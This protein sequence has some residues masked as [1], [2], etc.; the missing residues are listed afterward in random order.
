M[1]FCEKK[2]GIM[3]ATVWEKEDPTGWYVFDGCHG[4][5]NRWM[6]EKFDGARL[7]WDGNDFFN[8]QG[9]KIRVPDF[10]ASKMPKIALDGEL[11]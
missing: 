7:F 5:Q 10:V 2:G 11:W 8:R 9:K 6:S 4:N 1:H 3:T